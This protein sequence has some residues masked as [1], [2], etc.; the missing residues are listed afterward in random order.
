[1]RLGYR[2]DVAFDTL[3]PLTDA[4]QANFAQA[5]DRRGRGTVQA[6]AFCGERALWSYIAHAMTP[7]RWMDVCGPHDRY[8]RGRGPL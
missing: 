2:M 6:C 1:M 3:P 4:E 8:L 7:P 5:I